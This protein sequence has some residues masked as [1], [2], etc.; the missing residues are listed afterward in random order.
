[1]F[2]VKAQEQNSVLFIGNSLT[3]S[4]DMPKMFQNIAVSFGKSIY[5][6]T[7]VKGGK[8]ISYHASQKRTY[9]KIKSRKWNYVVIQGFSLE[10]AQP[11]EIIDSITIPNL[12][13]IVDSVRFYNPCSKIILYE[14]W[15]YKLGEETLDSAG[16][17]TQMQQKI[18]K[19]TKRVADIFRL[20]ICPVGEVWR[21]VR[22]TDENIELY[23]P[24]NYHPNRTGSYLSACT[25]YTTIYGESSYGNKSSV[26]VLSEHKKIIETASATTL[27]GNSSRWNL[28]FPVRFPSV[29]FDLILQNNKLKLV[30]KSMFAKNVNWYFGDGTTSKETNPIHV[31]QKKG[32][33]TINQVVQ[34]KCG[35]KNLKRTVTVTAVD[36]K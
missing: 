21:K 20:G 33:Y 31:Y 35:S 18:K 4:N 14:T 36:L 28:D 26:N 11:K 3:F 8:S 27:I 6:D 25:F 2:S 34:G 5:V 23:K 32:T 30:D 1:M 12:K 29:G 7:V 24:D 13:K 10:F 17:Y 16:D 15:G 9:R 19:Q 22:M